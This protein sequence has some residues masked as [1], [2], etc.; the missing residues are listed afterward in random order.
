MIAVKDHM[1][2]F[3]RRTGETPYPIQQTIRFPIALY[4][5]LSLRRI[6]EK[7]E[8]SIFQGEKWGSES[9]CAIDLMSLP[10]DS[11]QESAWLYERHASLGIAT[12]FQ[13]LDKYRSIRVAKLREIVGQ[14]KPALIIFYSVSY[15]KYWQAVAGATFKEVT[16]QM[17]YVRSGETAFCVIPQANARGMSYARL[18]EFANC[19]LERGHYDKIAAGAPLAAPSDTLSGSER[20][21]PRSEYTGRYVFANHDKLRERAGRTNDPRHI[22]YRAMLTHSTYDGYE[23]EMGSRVVMIP[24]RRGQRPVTG[25][26]EIRYARCHRGWIRNASN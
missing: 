14:Y 22:F 11:T 3:T 7:Y 15:N 16:Q 4:L 20:M 2:W 8:I 1:L 13:Y 26:A 17:Y 21:S 12:R 19:I 5:Y 18:Y 24:T 25:H 10:S 6:P 23:A 9:A